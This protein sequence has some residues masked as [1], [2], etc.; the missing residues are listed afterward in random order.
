MM[1]IANAIL[2][3][4]PYE[5]TS[6]Q[7]QLA[8]RLE[9]YFNST[10]SDEVFIL[11]GYAG[12]GKTTFIAALAHILPQFNWTVVLLAPTGRAAKV[13]AGYAD[14]PANTIH[15]RIYKPQSVAGGGVRFS[16][17]HNF[18]KNT[19][20]IVDEASM[21]GTSQGKEQTLYEGANVLSDLLEYV[22]TGSNC[23]LL[24]SG[25]VAQLP[26]VGASDSPALTGDFFKSLFI[27]AAHQHE[28]TEVVRQKSSSGIL[29]NATDLRENITAQNTDAFTFYTKGFKDI[30]RLEGHEIQ[31][32]LETSYR[33]NGVEGTTLITRSNKRANAYNLRIR[34][35][36]LDQYEPIA[37]GDYLMAVKNNYFWLE[38][39]SKAGFIANGDILYVEKV[40][41]IEDKYGFTF[42]DIQ[43][44][45]TDYPDELPFDLKVN[46]APIHS[47]SPA[48]SY[49]ESNILFEALMEEYADLPTKRQRFLELKKNP[50]YNAL[51]VKFG[52]A[53]TCHK[54]QGGQWNHVYVENY[55]RPDEVNT[56]DYKRWLYTAITRST[57]KVF[58]LNFNDSF[59]Q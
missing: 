44:T 58:L 30:I 8:Q 5:P 43:V 18:A 53:V 39:S 49:E 42:A 3:K 32:Q 31:E 27:N 47:D 46:I 54:S 22:F 2:G 26:P 13:L 33:Q 4:L 11:R 20:F 10:V 23:K 59:F 50:F 24:F 55:F 25:D 1:P 51:Q 37:A 12:T 6:Q 56:V 36:I 45:M 38:P 41:S 29:Y 17:G 34:G 40:R 15:R 57:D 52:Y 19:V 35:T 7:R 16:L 28:L 14:L 9:G 48:L 21:I